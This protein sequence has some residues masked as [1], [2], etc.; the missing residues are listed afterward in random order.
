MENRP[1]ITPLIKVAELLSFY[2]EL[3]EKLISLSQ[4]F[5]KL[6]NPL[7]RKTIARVATLQQVAAVGN[8]PLE[9]IIN[10]LRMAAG[11]T[12]ISET[13]NHTTQSSQKP[14]WLN[15][16][17]I[18]E[19]LD[20]REMLARGEHPLSYVLSRMHELPAGS[21]FELVTS[22]RPQPLIE[23]VAATGAETHT[24][25]LVPGEFHNYFRK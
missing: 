19:T 8:I 21:I 9:T 7:L 2:P 14:E 22:F 5:E 15:N 11:Q 12:P 4:A 3:E 24:E 1:E 13:M 10:T 23:K 20:A 18:S 6:R 25:E 16:S 17:T